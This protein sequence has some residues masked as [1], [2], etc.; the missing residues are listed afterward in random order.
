MGN[1]SLGLLVGLAIVL[2]ASAF[3]RP[4]QVEVQK[5]PQGERGESGQVLGS[6]PG[7][8]L[9]SVY[10]GVNGV[11]VFNFQQGFNKASS[12]LCAIQS[13]EAT[14]TLISAAGELFTSTS[15]TAISI[16]I[17]K[18]VVYSGATSSLVSFGSSY[19]VA[20]T[21]GVIVASTTNGTIFSPRTWLVF[22]G[23]FAESSFVSANSLGGSCRARFMSLY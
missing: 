12:T 8:D 2:S 17:N 13:P 14:S 1:K 4:A 5:G 21:K 15:T 3:L 11:K 6:F 10:I 22:T 19:F 7:A 23:A 16:D 9:D 20:G 18:N